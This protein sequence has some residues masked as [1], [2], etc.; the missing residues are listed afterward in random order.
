LLA[1]GRHRR[2][3]C[4]GQTARSHVSSWLTPLRHDQ[5]LAFASSRAEAHSASG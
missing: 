5:A 4:R 1:G 2:S 3:V